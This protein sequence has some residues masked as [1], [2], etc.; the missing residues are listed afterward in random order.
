LTHSSGKT[1]AV[2]LFHTWH[3]A[4][5]LDRLQQ[6]DSQNRV[7]LLV[8]VNRSLLKNEEFA[9]K[10]KSSSYFSRFGFY[11][12]EAPTAAKIIPLLESWIKE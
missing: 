1:V 6:L 5:L 10:V 7:P 3:A 2:E 12:R 9:E 8:G 4:P 11:F